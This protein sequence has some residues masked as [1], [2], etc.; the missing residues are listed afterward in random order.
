MVIQERKLTRGK[1]MRAVLEHMSE[2]AVDAADLFDVFVST[3]YGASYG[4][5]DHEFR[6]RKR[7]RSQ[8]AEL[9]QAWRRHTVL[10]YQL[11]KDGIIEK[12]ESRGSWLFSLT[13]KGKEKLMVLRSYKSM[14]LPDP[15]YGAP[16]EG[17][18]LLIV[19]F[20]IPERERTK[21]NWLR[22][23]LKNLG[24]RMIQ[25]S[26]WLGAVR[27]PER[28]LNDLRKIHLVDSVEIFTVNK[29]GTLRHVI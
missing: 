8:S 15:S 17:N 1:I 21:R 29:R 22:A 5:L 6:K 3:R 28:F 12:K 26:V 11:H 16:E 9:E 14:A 27:L 20:D 2:M 24:L 18:D 4:K 7:E 10:L 23:V 25:Q 13:K 19:S